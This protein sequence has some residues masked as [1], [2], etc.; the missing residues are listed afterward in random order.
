MRDQPGNDC[1]PSDYDHQDYDRLKHVVRGVITSLRAKGS[2]LLKPENLEVTMIRINMVIFRLSERGVR[3]P[4]L[5]QQA[6]EASL[7]SE[8]GPAPSGRQ[9]RT[10]YTLH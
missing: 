1:I 3:D 2:P 9:R 7:L 8:G 4:E 5:L 10:L 6:T